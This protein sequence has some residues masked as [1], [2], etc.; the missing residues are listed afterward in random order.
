[1]KAGDIMTI[2][3]TTVGPSAT[4]REVANLLLKR[5]IS[6]VPVVDSDNDVLGIISE[7]DLMRRVKSNTLARGSWWLGLFGTDKKLQEQFIKSHG[8]TAEQVMTRELVTVSPDT[9]VGD[10]ASLLEK[11]S[12][13]RAPV[14]ENGKLV[15]IVSRANLLHALA[16]CTAT[17]ESIQPNDRSVRESVVNAL[18]N[19]KSLVGASINPIVNNGNVELWGYVQDETEE[20]AAIVVTQEVPGVQKVQSKLG[21]SSGWWY[22]I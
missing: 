20:R 7:G 21:R 8:R 13:K 2:D 12:I 19:S 11:H 10:V 9:P 4:V 15:G 18:S 6:G 17:T 5:R 14:I 22:G 1:M 16:S 3:V